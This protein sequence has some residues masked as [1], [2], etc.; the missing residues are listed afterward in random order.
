VCGDYCNTAAARV[1][2]NSLGFGYVGNSKNAINY[3]LGTGQIWL[4]NV[5]CEGSE[6]H[7][8][9]CPHVEW[10]VH[11]CGHDE[12]IAVLCFEN[13]T[14]TD[15]TDSCSTTWKSWIFLPVVVSPHILVL[16]CLFHYC[17]VGCCRRCA[18]RRVGCCRNGQ[19][20]RTEA[21][22]SVEPAI[23]DVV[24]EAS[25]LEPSARAANR[26]VAEPPPRYDQVHVFDVLCAD[27]RSR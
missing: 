1:V 23:P 8:S 7:F 5:W 19:P 22:R 25:S 9:E 11:N 4:N 17:F 15:T 16:F 18:Q 20:E 3:G 24:H 14:T 26:N 27:S 10:G 12:D 2:C 6:R 21:A 13:W